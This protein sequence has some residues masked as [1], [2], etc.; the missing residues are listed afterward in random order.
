MWGGDEASYLGHSFAS[1]VMHTGNQNVKS[2]QPSK[3]PEMLR[4]SDEWKQHTNQTTRLYQEWKR[5][6]G[7]LVLM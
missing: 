2:T 6:Y 5:E 1:H 4:A 3:Q 7:R